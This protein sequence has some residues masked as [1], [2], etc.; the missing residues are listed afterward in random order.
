MKRDAKLKISFFKDISK[1]SVG[2]QVLNILLIIVSAIVITYNVG[3][4]FNKW[5]N[6]LH[7]TVGV[8]TILA[9]LTICKLYFEN[10]KVK[11][12]AKRKNPRTVDGRRYFE[13]VDFLKRY[14]GTK[15]AIIGDFSADDSEAI[16]FKNDLCKVFEKSEWEIVKQGNMANCANIHMTNEII[17]RYDNQ[18]SREE[19]KAVLRIFERLNCVCYEKAVDDWKAVEGIKVAI[20]VGR[21]LIG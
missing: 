21:H 3:I 12:I 7:I 14:C 2:I 9:F 10:T 18:S 6:I 13:I 20:T 19:G 1:L 11:T 4:I 16:K 17:V 8:A 15:I 5:S